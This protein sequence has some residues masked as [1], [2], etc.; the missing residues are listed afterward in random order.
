MKR[1]L[2]C[3]LVDLG[4]RL[5]PLAAF[6]SWLLRI[7]L[8]GCPACRAG[9]AEREEV[10]ELFPEP[11]DRIGA[12]LAALAAGSGSQPADGSSGHFEDRQNG[13]LVRLYA[14]T[15]AAVI[16]ILLAG[17]GWYLVRKGSGLPAPADN[18][19]DETKIVSR[20]SLDYVRFKGQPAD[21][22]IYRTDD[23]DM[24]IIWVE[25]SN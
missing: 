19:T 10:R 7:H 4:W 14:G 12:G 8:D 17:F 9:L 20:V 16:V 15:M 18:D 13:W 5:V 1:R 2:W 11:E 23:P 3:L 24:V 6:R 21:T 25:G 22:Y